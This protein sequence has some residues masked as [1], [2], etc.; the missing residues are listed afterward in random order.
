MTF[1]LGAGNILRRCRACQ[2]VSATE[3][4]DP[5]EI[6]VDGYLFGEVGSFGLDVRHPIFQQYL[7]RVAERRMSFIEGVTGAPGS[8][9]DVG[10][11][12]GEVMMAA[13]DRSWAVQGVE[14]ERTGAEMAQERGLDV[15][16]SMLEDSGLPERSYDVVSAFHVLE[17]VPDSRR[18]LGTLRRFARPG[19][20]VVIEVPNFNSAQRRRAPEQWSELRPLE[21]LVHFTPETLRET[22]ER[23]GLDPVLTRSPAYIG[24]PQH[25]DFA[26]ADL[27]RGPRF[28]RLFQPLTTP[29][30]IAGDQEG[31]YPNKLGW[32]L[33]RVVEAVYDRAGAGAVVFCVGRVP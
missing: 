10:S 20:Y 6:Y 23:S 15:K 12:T 14:P 21:H 19:G 4:A 30:Q 16:V 22:F 32:T 8:M 33:L 7:M 13:R 11:G 29:R 28:Q 9:L 25:L 3:Y 24:P 1:D 31:R 17:H 18:F 26:M 5:S 2:T 27:A